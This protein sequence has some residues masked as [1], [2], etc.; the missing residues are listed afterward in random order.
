MGVFGGEGWMGAKV[1][2]TRREIPSLKLRFSPLQM[3]GWNTILSY[4]VSAYFQGLCTCEFQGGGTPIHFTSSHVR[5]FW[6]R[7][8]E[9]RQLM[10]QESWWLRN[11][12]FGGT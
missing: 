10:D 7:T 2:L 3:D 9:D 5:F 6:K 12:E 1:L 8:R 4:W 11:L